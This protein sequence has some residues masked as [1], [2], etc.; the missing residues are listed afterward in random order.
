ATYGIG[1]TG[2]AGPGGGTPQKPVGLVWI[3]LAC[4]EETYVRKLP[5]FGGRYP[6]RDALRQHSAGM[7]LDMLRRRLQGRPVIA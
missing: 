4:P 7:A 1:I 5:P 2:I 3:A 6:G